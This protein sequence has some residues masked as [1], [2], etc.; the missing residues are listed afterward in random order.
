MDF[1]YQRVY[2]I[3]KDR[4][5]DHITIE[6]DMGRETYTSEQIIALPVYS[7]LAA[8]S[9]TTVN[10][11]I[12]QHFSLPAEWFAGKEDSF[13]MTVKGDSMVGAN[14]ENGDTV[15]VQRL[16]TAQNRD[17]V[18]VAIDEEATLKRFMSMGDTILLIPE[19]EKYEPILMNSDQ[20]RVVGV[21]MG[22]DRKSVV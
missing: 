13:L 21:A 14:I 9:P 18:V 5:I 3:L 17:I 19:N 12:T 16:Q 22:V 1:K 4:E 8:G 2:Q 20:V 6:T 15:V 11:E 10:D 7:N